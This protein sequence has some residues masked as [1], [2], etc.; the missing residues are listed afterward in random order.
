MPWRRARRWRLKRQREKAERDGRWQDLSDDVASSHISFLPSLVDDAVSINFNAFSTNVTLVLDS[1]SNFGKIFITPIF[2]NFSVCSVLNTHNCTQKA[3]NITQNNSFFFVLY[4]VLVY[5]EINHKTKLFCFI[6]CKWVDVHIVDKLHIC[7][8][9]R[10]G[11]RWRC[12]GNC[13][14]SRLA[15]TLR[16]IFVCSCPKL[17]SHTATSTNQWR[18]SD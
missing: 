10:H 18:G 14:I 15:K 4:N 9:L 12:M 5:H 17:L 1:L 7:L 13:V 3:S 6:F 16:G 8:S 11:E 2:I